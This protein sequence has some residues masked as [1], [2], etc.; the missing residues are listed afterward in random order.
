MVAEGI[1]GVESLACLR[2]VELEADRPMLLERA[3][4][5]KNEILAKARMQIDP[6]IDA[7]IRTDYNI[8]FR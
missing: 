3:I 6:Q 4:Q 2:V 8:Y 5:R 7:A 1:L